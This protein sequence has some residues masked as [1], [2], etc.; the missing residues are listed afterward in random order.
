MAR[1]GNMLSGTCMREEEANIAREPEQD[2][3]IVIKRKTGELSVVPK[4]C[5]DCVEFIK[6]SLSK[7]S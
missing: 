2:D 1:V 5:L 6:L 3:Q 7:L 4:F